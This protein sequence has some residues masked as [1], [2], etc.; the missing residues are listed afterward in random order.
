MSG[1]V[2]VDD[3]ND[4]PVLIPGIEVVTAWDYLT[5]ELHTRARKLRVYNLCRSFGYQTT[6][7]YVS[8]LAGARGHKPLPEITTI[9][10]LKLAE[11]PRFLND[12]IEELIQRSLSPIGSSEYLLN[13]YFGESLA[14]RHERLARA[15]FNL[16]PA[17][18]L[19]AR[20]VYRGDEWRVETLGP[21]ALGE[22]PGSH[23]EFLYEAARDYF[24]R[25][26]TPRTRRDS[27]RYDLAIL[28]NED[29]KEPPSNARALKAFEKAAEDLGF[30]VEFLDKS[31]YGHVAE[32]D[33][34]FIRE[35]TAVNHHTYRFARRAARE[36]LVVVDDP[37]SI[38]RAANKV[39]LAQ[40]MERHRIPQPKTLLLHSRNVKQAARELG[41]PC[42]L[43]QPD[44]QFS[45]GVIKV[46]SETELK[47][48]ATE[49]LERSDLIIAQSYEPTEYDWRVGVLDGQPLYACRYYMA[50]DHWQVVKRGGNGAVLEG[51]HETLDVKDVPAQV[52]NVA[53]QAARAVGEGLYGVDLKQF[54]KLVKVIEVN[55]N[56]NVDFGVEDL[57]LKDTL[58]QKIMAYFARRLEQRT[59]EQSR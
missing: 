26:R 48:A 38:L 12:E 21:I 45:K 23:L 13:V 41:F 56:P 20:F 25:K 37:L 50:K 5:H 57:V 9:Q 7:Y 59:R 16:F 31:D 43:K 32:F 4:W 42:V 47:R 52:L 6:G 35:T 22:V 29:E 44:S 58:Y 30:D 3:R 36:G 18:L 53:V 17:P 8:L 40:L 49:M 14:K 28:I 19:Q 46:D 34:L 55:D 39:F 15:L 2:V 27:A 1:I 24:A 11:S 51:S 33:A 54:G 10:D